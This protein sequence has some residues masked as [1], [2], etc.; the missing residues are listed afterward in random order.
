[1]RVGAIFSAV[2]ALILW[3]FSTTLYAQEITQEHYSRADIT[4]RVEKNGSL[5]IREELDYVKARGATTRGIFVELPTKVREGA[6]TYR[7]NYRLTLAT[8]NGEREAVTN[9]SDAGTI[10]WRLGRENVLLNEGVQK[11]VVEYE[12]DDWVMRYDD[13]DEIRW[14]LWGEY[15]NMPVQSF[16]GRIILP[17]GASAKQVAAYSG[18]FGRTDNDVTV[19]QAGNIIEFTANTPLRPRE[20]VTAAVGVEKGVFDP[21]SAAEISAR[22]WLANGALAGLALITPGVLAFYFLNWSRV[23]RDPVKPPVFARYEAPKNYSAAAAHRILNKGIKGDAPLISTLL[24]LAIK[25]RIE[26][27]VTKKQTTLTPLPRMSYADA[28]LNKEEGLLFKALFKNRMGPIVLQKDQPNTGFYIAQMGFLAQ[29][30]KTY[31]RPYHLVNGKYIAMGIVLTVMGVFAVLSTFST[32]SSLL[33]W[34]LILGLVLINLVFMFLMPAPTKKGAQIASEIEGFKLYLETAEKLRLNAAEIGTDQVPPMTVERYEAFLPYA[35]ALDVEKPWTKHFENTLPIA[36]ETYNPNYYNS[37][38]GGGIGSGVGGMQRDMVK[39][40]SSGVASARPVQTSSGGG[41]SS[42]RSFSGG[43][44]SSG[45]GGGGG[46]RG[47][48]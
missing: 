7:K 47:S 38:R 3:A 32:P 6:I 31:S 4:V 33:F 36:A 37:Y 23:G 1:M 9:M 5:K 39:A 19:T 28:L 41:R 20:A 30:N 42:G 26:I 40:L 27:D 29:L 13:L 44:G 22:W 45:G 25:K 21:L 16:T 18:V 10:I 8:R 15:T 48:W 34:G 46:G 35:V 24:S 2:L 12:T 14:N 43:G 11:Y 17:D